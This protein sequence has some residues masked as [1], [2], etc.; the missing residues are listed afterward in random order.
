MT[1]EQIV[2]ALVCYLGVIAGAVLPYYRKRTNVSKWD[3]KYTWVVVLASAM[4]L[5]TLESTVLQYAAGVTF[6]G[7]ILIPLFTAFL[8]G[9]G[10][11]AGTSEAMKI[12]QGMKDRWTAP[13][14]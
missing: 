4:S 13:E 11:V 9:F 10:F 6:G 5:I 7:A 3:M 14:E 2:V 12:L 8:T 1:A